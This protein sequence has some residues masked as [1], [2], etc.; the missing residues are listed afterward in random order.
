MCAHQVLGCF[1]STLIQLGACHGRLLLFTF[2]LSHSLSNQENPFQTCICTGRPDLD[3]SS[4]GLSFQG[5]QCC[6]KLT[7]KVN[8]LTRET[9]HKSLYTP[10]LYCLLYIQAM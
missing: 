4:L 3:K 2:T 1:F 7:T 6:V 9:L 8:D 10:S 5:S